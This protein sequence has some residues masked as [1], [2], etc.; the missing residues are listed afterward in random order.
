MK[1][2]LTQTDKSN[3]AKLLHKTDSNITDKV[4]LQI[5]NRIKFV[6]LNWESSDDDKLQYIVESICELN[7]VIDNNLTGD[8]EQNLTDLLS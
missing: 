3:I 4:T 2:E 7:K 5:V 1:T 8:F 6:V